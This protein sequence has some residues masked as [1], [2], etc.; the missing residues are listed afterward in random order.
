MT[1]RSRWLVLVYVCGALEL[2]AAAPASAR[3]LAEVKAKGEVSLCAHPDALPYASQN[4]TPPGFQI[5][6]GQAV[7]ASL[8]VPL[9]VEWIVPHMRAALVD[10]DML[11]DAVADPAVHEGRLKLSHAYQVNGVGLVLR[12]GNDSVRGLGDLRAEQKVGVMINSVASKVVNQRGVRTAPYAFEEDML[13]DMGKGDIDGAVVSIPRASYYIRTHPDA[14]FRL[15]PSFDGAPDLRWQ[16]A[17]GLR[18]SDEAMV[19]AVNVALE[20]MIESGTLR[21]I[22]AKYGLQLLGP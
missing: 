18:R 7:A 2:A 10:C 19:Q 4:A 11:L 14:G 21:E 17:V 15:V 8:G 20:R 12:P 6:I 22:Y 3:T 5:E 13:E 9:K 16:V 1:N